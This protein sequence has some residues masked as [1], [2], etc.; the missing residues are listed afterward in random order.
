MTQRHFLDYIAT[1]KF[2]RQGG[3]REEEASK[4]EG[5]GEGR[6]DGR[7][8]WRRT[9]SRDALAKFWK[10]HSKLNLNFKKTEVVFCKRIFSQIS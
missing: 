6:Q 9:F 2:E 4:K 7:S 5:L 1:G 10:S 3:N 8:L